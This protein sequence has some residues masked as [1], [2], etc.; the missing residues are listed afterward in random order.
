MLSYAEGAQYI[1]GVLM[2]ERGSGQNALDLEAQQ[3][4]QLCDLGKPHPS[5]NNCSLFIS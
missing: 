1:L 4:S 3:E 2:S 5:L